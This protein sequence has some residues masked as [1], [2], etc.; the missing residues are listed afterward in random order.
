[1]HI[2]IGDNIRYNATKIS[3]ITFKRDSLS[4]IGLKYVMFSPDIKKNLI[5]IAVLEDHGH[6][7]IFSKG[8]AFVRHITTR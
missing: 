8:K 5:S 3:I 4:P 1:M 6:D 7:V 2:E